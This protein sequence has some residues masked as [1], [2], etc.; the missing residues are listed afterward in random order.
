MKTAF[1]KLLLLLLFWLLLL[2]SWLE[3]GN[4]KVNI[5]LLPTNSVRGVRKN[6]IIRCA[7]M[8]LRITFT[9]PHFPMLCI[10]HFRFGYLSIYSSFSII[11]VSKGHPTSF[12]L[13]DVN[14]QIQQYQVL[15]IQKF[16]QFWYPDMFHLATFHYWGRLLFAPF[17][18]VFKAIFVAELTVRIVGCIVVSP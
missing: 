15:L 16:Y 7:Q 14:P 6:L 18:F 3:N 12:T 4:L 2:F 5:N 13:Q 10:F 1:K 11:L 9:F 17:I 8:F